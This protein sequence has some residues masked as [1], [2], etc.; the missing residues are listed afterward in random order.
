MKLGQIQYDTRRCRLY[1][2]DAQVGSRTCF[3]SGGHRGKSTGYF[4]NLQLLCQEH[5]RNARD[6]C[7]FDTQIF[8]LNFASIV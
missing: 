4:A 5:H 3:G 2:E 1:W 6:G 8:D 7:R